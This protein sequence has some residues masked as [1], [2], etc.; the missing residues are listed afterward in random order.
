MDLINDEKDKRI[1]EQAATIRLLTDLTKA[2]SWVISYAPDGSA[3]SVQ[4]GDGFRRLMGYSDRNDFPD[5]IGSLVNGVYP[6]DRDALFSEL[7]ADAYDEEIMST[8]GHD[9]RFCRKDGSVRW[10]RSMGVLSRDPEGRPVQY[11]GVTIDI[12]REKEHDALYAA[13]QN[14][15]A[16]LDTHP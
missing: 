7:N 5:E 6:E 11:R 9:F 1:E 12:T 16:S 13:L 8:K 3:A 4:W 2:G 10:Y 14:E 15:A